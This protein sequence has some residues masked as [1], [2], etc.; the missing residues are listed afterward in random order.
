MEDWLPE[1]FPQHLHLG[2]AEAAM[3][4]AVAFEPANGAPALFQTGRSH[5]RMISGELLLTDDEVAA[6]L[7]WFEDTVAMGTKQFRMLRTGT[8]EVWVS[9]FA[10]DQPYALTGSPGS[11][12]VTLNLMHVRR[13]A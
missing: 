9:Q 3:R 11:Y 7:E 13:V 4:N 1:P 10:V 5:A 8:E 12:R 2:N 6:F